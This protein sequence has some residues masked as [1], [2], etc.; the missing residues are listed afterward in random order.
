MSTSAKPARL[1]TRSSVRSIVPSSSDGTVTSSTARSSAD[2][3]VVMAREVLGELVAR[4]LLL[5]DHAAD[6]ARLLEHGEV[7]VHGALRQPAT[8]ARISGIAR[9][10]ARA[11]QQLD[12]LAP[13][14][15]VALARRRAGAPRRSCRSSSRLGH[16]CASSR[17]PER[18]AP[19]A[20]APRPRSTPAAISTIVPPGAR[21]QIRRGGEPSDDR[22]D[23]DRH[24]PPQRAAERACE[25]L[26]ARDGQDHHRRDR[27]GCPTIRIAGDRRR[28]P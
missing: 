23:A 27:A 28:R 25:Q 10:A 15:R 9:R 24:A 20:R 11:A 7:A 17:T 3:M 19:V 16:Q 4:E 26:P 13:L 6:R 18:A 2:Q 14:R 21:P 5:G 22:D 12:E 8:A 1:A